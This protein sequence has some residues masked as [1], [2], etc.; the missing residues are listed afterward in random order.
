MRDN[1]GQDPAALREAVEPWLDG[2]Y[3][4]LFIGEVEEGRTLEPQLIH[5]NGEAVLR[6]ILGI[7][8][9]AVLE[10]WMTREKTEAAIRIAESGQNIVAPAYM[11]AAAAF[12]HG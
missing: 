8:A 2:E 10:V 7:R 6:G 5:H 9:D 3:R 1:D 4:E 12:I 11:A